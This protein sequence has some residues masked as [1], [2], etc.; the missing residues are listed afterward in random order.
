MMIVGIAATSGGTPSLSS[1]QLGGV[2]MQL[3]CSVTAT[4]G[5][6]VLCSMYAL[7]EVNLPE[8]ASA[9]LVVSGTFS[10]VIA[11]AILVQNTDQSYSFTYDTYSQNSR[12]TTFSNTITITPDALLIDA[13]GLLNNGSGGTANSGQTER[14]DLDQ[15]SIGALFM[16]HENGESS[17][18]SM[19]WSWSNRHRGQAHIIGALAYSAPSG[20]GVEALLLGTE[21]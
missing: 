10:A 12:T 5:G 17:S 1:V 18:E 4:Y 9:N 6:T 8:G 13:M 15:G 21:F 3:I 2:S 16:S 19:G 7:S 11:G 14:V 20:S